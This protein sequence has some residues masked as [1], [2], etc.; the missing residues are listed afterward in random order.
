MTSLSRR[1]IAQ[2]PS[3]KEIKAK[4]R[5]VSKEFKDELLDLLRMQNKMEKIY[6]TNEQQVKEI[7]EMYD[8]IDEYKEIIKYLTITPAIY[9]GKKTTI[10]TM[11]RSKDELE[12]KKHLIEQ[13]Q[14]ETFNVFLSCVMREK[15]QQ[16]NYILKEQNLKNQEYQKQRL[17][18]LN[19]QI[20]QVNQLGGGT[21][22]KQSIIFVSLYEHSRELL[23]FTK[24][25]FSITKQRY[26]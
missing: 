2:R 9:N 18:K 22:F 11:I 23:Y 24:Q 3:R 17:M 15:Q 21:V 16:T 20:I 5:I 12:S 14:L 7:D 19:S 13:E 1:A 4:R 8:K 26:S 6:F 10:K 25:H